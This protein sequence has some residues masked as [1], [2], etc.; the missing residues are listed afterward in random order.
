MPNLFETEELIMESNLKNCF[1]RQGDKDWRISTFKAKGQYWFFADELIR[2]FKK[3]NVMALRKW[4]GRDNA[5][6]KL[7]KLEN[8]PL[9]IEYPLANEEGFVEILDYINR[10]NRFV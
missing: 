6:L 2:A 4:A 8:D 9:P 7:V 3:D 10:Q 1:L 5:G